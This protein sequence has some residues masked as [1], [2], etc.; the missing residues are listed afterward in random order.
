MMMISQNK[1]LNNFQ[2]IHKKT[3]KD[4]WILYL[5]DKEVKVSDLSCSLDKEL[6]FL[7]V[8][9]EQFHKMHIRCIIFSNK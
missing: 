9:H 2:K 5:K 1:P 4:E 8:S 3:I 7:V 6:P